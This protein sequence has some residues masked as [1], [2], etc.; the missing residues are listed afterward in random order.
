MIKITML[1]SL[2]VLTTVMYAQTEKGKWYISGSSDISYSSTTT[3][4]E[5]DGEEQGDL[6]LSQFNI[7]PTIGY[8]VT[9]GLAVGLSFNVESSKQDDV[10]SNSIL[11]GPMAKYYFGTSNIKPFIQGGL[12]FGSQKEDDDVDE[13]KAKASAWDLSGGVALFINDFASVD[14][15]L[16]YGSATLTSKDDD[17]AKL[18]VNGLAF[19]VGFS[20]YF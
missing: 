12:Y 3:T 13:A 10:T 4:Y 18:K 6:D 1:L 2:L 15:G 9:D 16:G 20:L 19:N 11:I 7:T 14:I 5:Y 17:K 8:F